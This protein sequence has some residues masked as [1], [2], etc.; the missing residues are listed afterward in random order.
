MSVPAT[1]VY[2]G[3]IACTP[4][5][6]VY[7]QHT[8]GSTI[9]S[10]TFTGHMGGGIRTLAQSFVAV[11][12]GADTTEDTLTT[13]IVPANQIGANGKLRITCH[14]L[15]SPN[16]NAKTGRVR[17]SGAGGQDTLSGSGQGFANFSSIKTITEIANQN[18]TNSQFI[19]TELFAIN[20][21]TGP[22][23]PAPTAVDTT[24][25]TTIVITGQKTVAG[26]TFTL[27]GYTVEV[28]SP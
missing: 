26:D 25:Q 6:A 8:S 1:A 28:I 21:A 18:A 3:G 13:I 20:A 16:A 23:R 19:N 4:D 12:A 10:P 27:N 14:W 15:V 9:D 11:S 7:V 24:V 2:N 5:G 17:F 22:L